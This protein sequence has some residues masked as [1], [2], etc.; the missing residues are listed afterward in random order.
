MNKNYFFSFI[1]AFCHYLYVRVVNFPRTWNF[2]AYTGKAMELELRLKM[3]TVIVKVKVD[4]SAEVYRRSAHADEGSGAAACPMCLGQK[5]HG[6]KLP[7]KSH[8]T[9]SFPVKKPPKTKAPSKKKNTQRYNKLPKQF[10]SCD[11]FPPATNCPLLQIDGASVPGATMY[12][13]TRKHSKD[14]IRHIKPNFGATR[15]F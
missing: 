4:F 8:R 14:V 2:V 11:K 5:A 10:A 3:M 12:T 9:T 13:R 6:K 15:C 7:V 1:V